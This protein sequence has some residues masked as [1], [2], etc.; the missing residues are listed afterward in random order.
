MKGEGTVTILI[1]R[2]LSA[3]VRQGCSFGLVTIISGAVKI[4]S[5]RKSLVVVSILFSTNLPILYVYKMV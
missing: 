1:I 2:S 5:L 3:E 4:K